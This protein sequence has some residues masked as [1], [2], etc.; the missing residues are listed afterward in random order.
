MDSKWTME[1]LEELEL[2]GR[3]VGLLFSGFCLPL[4]LRV[5]LTAYSVFFTSLCLT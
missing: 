3:T 2:K 5:R 4:F 1:K